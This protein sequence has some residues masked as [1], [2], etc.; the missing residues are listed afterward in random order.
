MQVQWRANAEYL[1]LGVRVSANSDSLPAESV[2]SGEYSSP[3]ANAVQIRVSFHPRWSCV[4]DSKPKR[5]RDIPTNRAC[6]QVTVLGKFPAFGKYKMT[7][8]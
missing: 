6:S 8:N 1:A 5:I 2:D 7:I 3:I 4:A